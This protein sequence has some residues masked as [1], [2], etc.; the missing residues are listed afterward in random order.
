M[1]NLKT[2]KLKDTWREWE[3]VLEVNHDL[4]TPERAREINEFW[5]S[6][7]Y[8]LEEAGQDAVKAVI[9]M[10]GE[11]L[12]SS[13]LEIGGGVCRDDHSAKRWTR[14]NLH[15]IEGWGGTEPGELFGWCGIRLVSADIEVNLDLELEDE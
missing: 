13:F 2:Y 15:E 9:K 6:P 3:I 12:A 10:A 11:R 7:D 14:E 4:L 8:R 1:S 5:T